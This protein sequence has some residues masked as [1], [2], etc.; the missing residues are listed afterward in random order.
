[1]Q[2]PPQ[3]DFARAP[4]MPPPDEHLAFPEARRGHHE[5]ARVQ[6]RPQRQW[7]GAFTVILLLLA[8]AGVG[9]HL[10]VIPLDV[11]ITWREP[12]G[13]AIRTDPPGASVRVDGVPMPSTAPTTVSVWRERKEH[14]IEAS[15]P[16]Y[17]TA[18]LS[19][20]YDKAASL[21][22]TLPMKVDPNASPPVAPTD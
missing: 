11:L 15:R 20:R 9:V 7:G 2:R 3:Q 10:W 19:V 18:R 22:F 6:F 1:V 8:A 14:V 13:L 5:T 17:Q 12:T 4:T 16:G 21:A